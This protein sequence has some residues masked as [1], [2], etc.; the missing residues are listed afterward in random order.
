[1]K[2]TYYFPHDFEP[3]SDPKIMALI[4]QYKAEGYGI[5]W[6]IIEMLHS[7]CEHKI[8]KK[9]FIYL[10]ISQQM[11]TSVE[12]VESII[13]FCI[14]PCELFMENDE[15]FW[16]ERVYQNIEFRHNISEKR[17]KAGKESARK[18]ALIKENSTNVEQVSTSV[19]QNPTKERK[20]KESKVN[21]N[22]E[23]TKENC[24]LNFEEFWMAYDKKIGD[25]VKLEKKWIALSD[26]DRKLIMEYIPKYKL[27]QPDKKFRKHPDTFF[28]NKSWHDELIQQT[29]AI[30][31]DG[32]P[33]DPSGH[34]WATKT[35]RY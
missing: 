3:T 10:A 15:Y 35:R 33:I 14:N 24:L 8:L 9:K 21:N 32:R 19:Q 12:Q 29:K 28:N 5:F 27:S 2:D 7:D 30:T 11:Q 13:K 17:S 26:E 16:S 18:R 25:K 20:G 1:M 22:K 4:G 6:R 23:I 34:I 31:E